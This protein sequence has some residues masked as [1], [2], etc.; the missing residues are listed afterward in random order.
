MFFMGKIHIETYRLILNE[1]TYDD[2]PALC[3]MLRDKDVMYAYEH[4]FSEEEAR[5]WLDRQ[6][7][8][9]N[10]YGYGLWG[11]RLKSEGSLI[12]QC[13]ITPQPLNGGE[14]PEIGYIFNKNFWHRGYAAEAA[15]ACREYGF[16]TLGA[17]ALYSIIRDNNL[18]S[19]R[20]A[21]RNGMTVCGSIV[22]HY[23]GTDMPHVVYRIT[24]D[25]Y[26]RI[27]D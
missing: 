27:Q 2:F 20:V 21:E 8:R 1:M 26:F 11:V 3:L 9:Y 6:I 14:V 16:R 4:A 22:K 15:S 13:G 12:G 5:E 25:E 19:R 18:P 7:M 24:A 23:Y 17:D 10:R